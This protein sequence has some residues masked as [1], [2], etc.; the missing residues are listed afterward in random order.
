MQNLLKF[1]TLNIWKIKN[2]FFYWFVKLKRLNFEKNLI[3][4]KLPILKIFKILIKNFSNNTSYYIKRMI[5]NRTFQKFH[6]KLIYLQYF[7]CFFFL[8]RKLFPFSWKRKIVWSLLWLW[9]NGKMK[10][11]ISQ[12]RF[13]FLKDFVLKKKKRYNKMLYYFLTK[14]S[15]NSWINLYH[16]NLYKFKKKIF[17]WITKKYYFLKK[18][19]TKL[20]LYNSFVLK[21]TKN[22]NKYNTNFFM[23]KILSR[24][25]STW[26]NSLFLNIWFFKKLNK[27]K[28]HFKFI[29]IK[30][31][32]FW[33]IFR[34]ENLFVFENLLFWKSIIN[35][36]E[37]VFS[38]TS[39]NLIFPYK[40]K[41]LLNFLE[42]RNLVV[43]KFSCIDSTEFYPDTFSF[44]YNKGGFGS[45]RTTF[46]EKIFNSFKIFFNFNISF[47]ERTLIYRYY[48]TYL[49]QSVFFPKK[50]W[51]EFFNLLTKI[52]KNKMTNWH[53]SVNLEW[54][55]LNLQIFDSLFYL[56]F[57]FSI[58]KLL[59]LNTKNWN[60][61]S[62]CYEKYPLYPWKNWSF[63]PFESISS[64]K[65]R[66]IFN[67]K[68]KI[69][70]ILKKKYL[71]DTIFFFKSFS[72]KS[73]F[74]K[75]TR[76]SVF[77]SSKYFTIHRYPT[78]VSFLKNSVLWRFFFM[79]SY[80]KIW[81]AKFWR[82][83]GDEKIS[84]DVLTNLQVTFW[85][86]FFFLKST[87]EKLLNYAFYFWNG[88]NSLNL[89]WN[90]SVNYFGK[91]KFTTFPNKLIFVG[92]KW[93]DWD[94]RIDDSFA[95]YWWNDLFFSFFSFLSWTY[96]LNYMVQFGHTKSTYNTTYKNF[97][98]MVYNKRF[99]L[100]LLTIQLNLKWNLWLL[101]KMFYLGGSICLVSSF[102]ILIEGLVSL[103]GAYSKQ[104]YTRYLW[105][106]GLVSNFDKIF[107][108]IKVKI[109]KAYSGK[110]FFS[111]KSIR[112]LMRL[113]FCSKGI[114]NN[115]SIDISFF[116]S[117]RTSYWIF[118]ES[119]ARFYPTVTIN[120]TAAFVVP[121][122]LDYYMVS[123]DYSLLSLSFY[124]NLLL[125][126]FKKA[127]LLW[128]LEFSIY[129]QKLIS[130]FTKYQL[131][132]TRSVLKLNELKRQF[133]KIYK[134]F[135]NP[136]FLFL[137][138]TWNNLSLF[139]KYYLFFWTKVLFESKK[140]VY[141]RYL[142]YFY[143]WNKI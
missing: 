113:W 100:N 7:W 54:L 120:N 109:S 86:S 39:E 143:F 22:S 56:F 34:F 137:D 19:L 40:L 37:N 138:F 52:Y 68:I 107:K 81:W 62:H 29:P 96:L 108:S 126:S 32:S 67:S 85:P 42:K 30:K 8:S 92:K 129:P 50:I 51:N 91:V 72:K 118:L 31:D 141:W 3:L 45:I 74:Q 136:K 36:S 84:Y 124:I 114:L 133:W 24:S 94:R 122:F 69:N 135:W 64:I 38:F 28:K 48:D 119:C 102:N 128:K 117:V 95:E 13:F 142:F 97:L 131:L 2:L 105:V 63:L 26:F 16:L 79:K 70:I 21:K 27:F 82:N 78:P 112:R 9:N 43:T 49:Q 103:Y 71:F 121:T 66:K 116:P 104:P 88:L 44:I 77:F 99:I 89:V 98:I 130:E 110:N 123:N 134:F 140:H 15:Y 23:K 59:I 14:Q 73:I 75:K 11:K 83:W 58:V 139:F 80:T 47:F 20:K 33:W 125:L 106:N 12:L 6:Y 65:K 76:K 132:T 127:K 90:F 61:I 1:K 41:S 57:K 101:F 53:I 115:L 55:Y 111:K 17:Y 4:N 46:F 10:K 60:S 35:L 5:Y 25:I 18:N 93:F 87:T